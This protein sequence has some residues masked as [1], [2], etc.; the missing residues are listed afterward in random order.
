MCLYV[1]MIEVLFAMIEVRK[2]FLLWLWSLIEVYLPCADNVFSLIINWSLF[3]VICW[4]YFYFDCQAK[5]VRHW[6]PEIF[7]LWS[8]IEVYLVWYA[9]NIFTLIVDR[10][11][12]AVIRWKY[13]YFDCQSKFVCCDVLKMFLLWSPFE[14]YLPWYTETIFTLIINRSLVLQILIKTQIYLKFI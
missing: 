6:Y 14:V 13:F 4:K 1:Y 5:F 10:S 11:L 8:S 2:I 12:F 7:L 3:A 9:E